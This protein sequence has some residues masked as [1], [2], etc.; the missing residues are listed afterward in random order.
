MNREFHL[1][2]TVDAIRAIID[3]EHH[4]V[5][6]AKGNPVNNPSGSSQ[7][8]NPDPSPSSACPQ[9]NPLR[10]FRAASHACADAAFCS[11]VTIP[12]RCDWFVLMYCN[13]LAH[14]PSAKTIWESW[15][16]YP[17]QQNPRGGY[18]GSSPR[19]CYMDPSHI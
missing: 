4:R 3:A 9:D 13:C 8:S 12:Y 2:E 5:N 14:L 16:V 1:D 10:M 17:N 15:C 18:G 19:A 6:S 11:L 7:E